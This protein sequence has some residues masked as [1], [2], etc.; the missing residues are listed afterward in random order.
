METNIVKRHHI[1]ALTRR[2]VA[3][4]ALRQGGAPM[5]QGPGGAILP[6]GSTVVLILGEYPKG[7]PFLFIYLKEKGDVIRGSPKAGGFIEC[8][9]TALK[10]M[11]VLFFP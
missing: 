11:S 3:G 2:A 10:A 5:P 1:M 8:S 7:I 6:Y 4:M 9:F